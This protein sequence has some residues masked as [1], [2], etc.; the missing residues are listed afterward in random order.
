M[1]CDA[2]FFAKV[3]ADDVHFYIGAD[4]AVAGL[5]V[6]IDGA[7]AWAEIA[8]AQVGVGEGAFARGIDGRKKVVA[9]DV[10]VKE[11]GWG[12]MERT[13]WDKAAVTLSRS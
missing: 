2:G 4:E 11:K 12:E 7:E 3:R 5:L 8:I 1:A 9:G 6:A 10:V 13:T